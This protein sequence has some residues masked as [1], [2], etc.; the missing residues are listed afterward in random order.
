MTFHRKHRRQPTDY[1]TIPAVH[2]RALSSLPHSHEVITYTEAAE[3]VG[4]D[5]CALISELDDSRLVNHYK[6]RGLVGL[7][8]KGLKALEQYGHKLE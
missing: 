1:D 2:V 3:R 6:S 8:T 4:P 5:A 7:T